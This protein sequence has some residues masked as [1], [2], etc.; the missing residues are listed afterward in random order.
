MRA[1]STAVPQHSHASVRRA[2]VGYRIMVP[3]IQWI[4]NQAV[5]CC[6]IKMILVSF[7][8]RPRRPERVDATAPLHLIKLEAY[9][10]SKTSDI[11]NML[12]DGIRGYR[13]MV[14]GTIR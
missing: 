6:F 11:D 14:P 5:T 3:H 2:L 13:I 10:Q 12:S 8:S 4:N 7:S 9:N 1:K